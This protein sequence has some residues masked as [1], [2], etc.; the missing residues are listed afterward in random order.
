MYVGCGSRVAHSEGVRKPKPRGSFPAGSTRRLIGSGTE[1]S[2]LWRS[3]TLRYPVRI[4]S[5]ASAANCHLTEGRSGRNAVGWPLWPPW[6]VD[7]EPVR[8]EGLCCFLA[9]RWRGRGESAAPPTAGSS[10]QSRGAADSPRPMTT[11]NPLVSGPFLPATTVRRTLQLTRSRC[12]GWCTGLRRY[13]TRPAQ[14][15]YETYSI[16]IYDQG[17][18]SP[19]Q[20]RRSFL[21]MTKSSP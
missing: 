21:G 15:G 12:T 19:S 1:P 8:P 14:T 3:H 18:C 17:L 16:T 11:P 13:N 9:R 4:R 20:A 7:S 10:G 2:S 6:G 5:T